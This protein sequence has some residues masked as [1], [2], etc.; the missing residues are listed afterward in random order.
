MTQKMYLWYF[1][2]NVSD[3]S[4]ALNNFHETA[5]VVTQMSYT[6]ERSWELPIPRILTQQRQRP[7]YKE[8]RITS[9][10]KVDRATIELV[11]RV[12]QRSFP[13]LV[14]EHRTFHS[15]SE[16]TKM[17]RKMEFTSCLTV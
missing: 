1:F 6:L 8:L 9:I 15:G 4:S 7:G 3:V 5:T 10:S 13:S 17:K 14:N 2:K 16:W 12:N 11:S